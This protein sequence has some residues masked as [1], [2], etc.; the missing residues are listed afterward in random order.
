MRK[1]WKYTWTLSLNILQAS[2]EGVHFIVSRQICL[3]A[4][5]ILQ[6]APWGMDGP[7]PYSPVDIEQTLLVSNA[8]TH[9]HRSNWDNRTN[10]RREAVFIRLISMIN[11]PFQV[12]II[13]G[14]II[15]PSKPSVWF[16]QYSRQSAHSE[17][18]CIQIS[19]QSSGFSVF[20]RPPHFFLTP[21]ISYYIYDVFFPILFILKKKKCHCRSAL[22][23]LLTDI[24]FG[25]NTLNFFLFNKLLITYY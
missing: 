7:P 16:K 18:H 6:E 13:H 22:Y 5:D 14:G 23:H 25:F 11:I 3:P 4:P 21:D 24:S 17:N 19:H 1:G 12:Q 20:P 10:T 8:H 2:E 15:P 9:T